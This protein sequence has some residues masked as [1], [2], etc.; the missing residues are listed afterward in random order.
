MQPYLISQLHACI[1]AAYNPPSLLSLL[2][3][4][5]AHYLPFRKR[6]ILV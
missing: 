1:H 5:F 4:D 3:E 2:F 6:L